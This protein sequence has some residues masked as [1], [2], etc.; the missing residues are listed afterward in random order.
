MA[1]GEMGRESRDKLGPAA[2]GLRKLALE[3]PVSMVAGAQIPVQTRLPFRGS[4]HRF[5]GGTR[6]FEVAIPRLGPGLC[7]RAPCCHELP[8]EFPAAGVG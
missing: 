7:L 5:R 3:R 2:S 1:R 6:G 8:Q 4:C